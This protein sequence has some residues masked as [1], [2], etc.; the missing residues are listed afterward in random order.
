MNMDAGFAIP[1]KEGAG[2]L[3][4]SCALISGDL[5]LAF[6][7][8]ITKL[9][10]EGPSECDITFLPCPDTRRQRELEAR[11]EEGKFDT[12][13]GYELDRASRNNHRPFVNVSVGSFSEL[14]QTL[15]NAS[16]AGW[17]RI[18]VFDNL[19]KRQISGEGLRVGE[20]RELSLVVFSREGKG[21]N[22]TSK[23]EEVPLQPNTQTQ[24][25]ATIARR[26]PLSVA[27]QVLTEKIEF[28]ILSTRGDRHEPNVNGLSIF[29]RG[30]YFHDPDG[31]LFEA[32][33]SKDSQLMQNE[34][35]LGD[36]LESRGRVPT[37]VSRKITQI[38]LEDSP[39]Q[40]LTEAPLKLN[41][42]ENPFFMLATDVRC[43]ADEAFKELKEAI[44]DATADEED[45][46][47]PLVLHRWK[48]SKPATRREVHTL[49]QKLLES[50]GTPYIFA[51]VLFDWDL[52][53]KERR[54]LFVQWESSEITWVRKMLLGDVF[55][56]WRGINDGKTS[57]R[58]S[59]SNVDSISAHVEIM[60]D[61]RARFF[62]DPPPFLSMPRARKTMPPV[63]FLTSQ[64][65]QGDVARIKAEVAEESDT[66]D[67]SFFPKDFC[68]VD[69]DK[70]EDGSLSDMWN[71]LQQCQ[72]WS[73]GRNSCSQVAFIDRQSPR[74]LKVIL[75]D[76]Q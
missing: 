62:D 73:G 4:I 31:R 8:R 70:A 33:S 36:V 20:L 55:R 29:E 26:M 44:H 54:L 57:G 37:E 9:M 28:H 19:S 10:P 59:L 30:L 49:F 41:R 72:Q 2:A 32:N 16:K 76:H 68:F 45:G 12:I 3:I 42:G 71:V 23:V 25:Q 65:S 58:G 6:R 34:R 69:W 27:L 17:G 51:V 52:W 13:D 21:P 75:V 18:A 11:K 5:E 39:F 63:F 46:K 66:D 38:A 1:Q 24:T 56:E 14:F 67:E 53:Y 50:N 15:A 43:A 22:T 61:P 40:D 47:Y 64:L 7:T 60:Q 74:D 35:N 48:H